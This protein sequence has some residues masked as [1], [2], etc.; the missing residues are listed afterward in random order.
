[1]RLRQGT[2]AG[3]TVQ[4]VVSVLH[5][6]A[7]LVAVVVAVRELRAGRQRDPVQ[8]RR[9]EG[10]GVALAVL[11]LGAVALGWWIS[12][13]TANSPWFAGGMVIALAL[14]AV[15]RVFVLSAVRERLDREA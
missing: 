15:G 6:T 5:L 1:M 3:M 8:R 13:F 10:I 9:V 4:L 2:V 11:A 12:G 14:T 7:V